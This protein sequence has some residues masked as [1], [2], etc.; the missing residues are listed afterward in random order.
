MSKSTDE[1]RE[2]YQ[3]HDD[4]CVF[5]AP[6]W[7]DAVAPDRW[8]AILIKENN[9]IVASF[10]YTIRTGR[11]G[12]KYICMPPLTQK[13]GPY[14]VFGNKTNQN[15]KI[16]FE[17]HMFDQIIHELPQFDSFNLSFD[18]IYQNWLPFY[19]NGFS[20]TTR[21][22]YRIRNISD[23]DEVKANFSRLKKRM[24]TRALDLKVL[25]DMP[26]DSF[27]SFFKDVV[28]ERGEE[29]EYDYDLF[30]RLYNA[31]Y[32]NNQGKSF[33]CCDNI[34]NIHAI[35]LI[36][37]DSQTAY[38]LVAMRKKEF[39]SSGATEILLYEMIN[40]VSKYVNQFDFEG[41]MIKEVEASFREYG[42]EQTQY[43]NIFKVNSKP[44]KILEALK[45]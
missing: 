32:L 26:V 16:N 29:V 40:Y 28:A 19:W 20:Q 8:D 25:Q 17:N 41:S 13:L 10:V 7:L 22:S 14:I 23:M 27:Y 36:V 34:G 37:W 18:Q 35:A 24:L 44:L 21:Y 3:K 45:K 12:M 42:T 5:S 30:K 31:V 4:I 2:F 1:Y 6:W 11:S 15:K 9:E 39:K 43:F 33:Y 38:Y